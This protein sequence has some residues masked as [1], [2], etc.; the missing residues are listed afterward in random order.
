MA[1]TYKEGVAYAVKSLSTLNNG[2]IY[3]DA[4]WTGWLGE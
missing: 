3:M 4:G 1:N 2:A